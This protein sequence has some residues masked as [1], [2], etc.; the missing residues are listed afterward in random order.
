MTILAID[1]TTEMCSVALWNGGLLGESISNTGPQASKVVLGMLDELFQTHSTKWEDISLLAFGHGPGSFTGVRLTTGLVQG[2][3]LGQ[4]L[5]VMGVSTLSAIAY[6]A[7]KLTDQPSSVLVVHDARMGELYWGCYRSDEHGKLQSLGP[8]T[9]SPGT[10][11]RIND[12][13]GHWLV[14]GN[15]CQILKESISEGSS[16]NLIKSGNWHPNSIARSAYIAELANQALI[17]GSNPVSAIDV[18]PVYIRNKVTY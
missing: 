13:E 3:A 8:E 18:S 9:V 7:I 11:V 16:I 4:N 10:E 5:Q 1:A 15:G 12:A 14:A 17:N 2:I 6:D